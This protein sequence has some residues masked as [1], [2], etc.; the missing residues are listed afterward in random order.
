METFLTTT[1]GHLYGGVADDALWQRHWFQLA[2]QSD[3][4]Y[5]PPSGA[6]GRRFTAILNVEWQ[7]VLDR[8]WNSKGPLVFAH[9]VLTKTLGVRR[10]R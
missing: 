7:G 9:I 8:S 5:A 10:S 3:G 2:A 6:V 4:L 1:M